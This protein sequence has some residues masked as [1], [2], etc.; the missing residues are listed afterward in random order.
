MHDVVIV[1]LGIGNIFSVENA[2]RKIGLNPLC[3]QSAKDIK[4]SRYLVL[5]GVGSFET[6][7]TNMKNLD[8]IDP[9]LN[10]IKT[11]KPFLGICLGMQILA[12]KG[13]EFGIHNGL[14]L[15]S[16]VVKKMVPTSPEERVPNIGWSNVIPTRSSLLFKHDEEKYFYHV[17][18][19]YL[20]GN[21]QSDS[22]AI[23]KYGDK[24]ITVAVE[25]DNILGVQ[26]H[27]EKSLDSGLNLLRNFIKR[28][29]K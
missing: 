15:I 17:H 24:D 4:N 28:S 14:G 6:A 3:S 9:I 5:P 16:G 2:F 22:S 21:N 8:L 11:G 23:I 7:M 10:E 19:Y 12:D 26:F 27:P 1:D 25:K 18:S 13:E 29:E 20:D